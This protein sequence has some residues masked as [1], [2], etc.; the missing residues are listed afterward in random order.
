MTSCESGT[1]RRGSRRRGGERMAWRH[2]GNGD[3]GMVKE[4]MIGT[5]RTLA[6]NGAGEAEIADREKGG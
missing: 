2:C 6:K 5:G 1:R 3:V 4:H